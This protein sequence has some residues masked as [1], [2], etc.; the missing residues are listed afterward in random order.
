MAGRNRPRHQVKVEN[1]TLFSASWGTEYWSK[2]GYDWY[3]SVENLDPQPAHVIVATDRKLP[4][5]SGY[6]QIDVREPYHW[7]AFNAAVEA[8]ETEWVAGLAIDDRLPP[9]AFVDI[10]MSGDVEASFSV[11]SEGRV[12]KPDNHKWSRIMGAEWYPLSG[13]QIVKRDVWMRHPLRPVVWADWIQALEWRAAEIQVKFTER[14]RHY[15]T[16]HPG[17]HSRVHNMREALDRIEL[18]KDMIRAGGI[19]PGNT[20]PPEPA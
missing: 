2:Y 13:Y 20:W 10:D 5:G 11:D 19:K 8:A 17:Q 16:C 3:Q 9:D 4:L 12:Y 7:E 6:Q 1:L 15:Y 14:V 18:V